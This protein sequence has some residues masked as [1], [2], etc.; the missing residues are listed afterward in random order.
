MKINQISYKVESDW[1]AASYFYS[2][3]ALCEDGEIVLN[4]FNKK[5]LQGDSCLVKI[6]DS[7]GVLSKFKKGEPADVLI[8]RGSIKKRFK[9]IF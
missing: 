9:V 6:Y 1:S 8:L 5:S 4:N 2:I 7:L 3:I